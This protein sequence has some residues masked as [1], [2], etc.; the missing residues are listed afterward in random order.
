MIAYYFPPLGGIGSL[1]TAKFASYLPDFGW[2][3]TVVAPRNGSYYRDP[4]LDSGEATVVRTGSLELSRL[5]KRAMGF[6]ARDTQ[7]AAAEGG[8]RFLRD[9]ARRWL[10]FPDAQI[11]WFPFALYAARRALRDATHSVV[12]SSSFPITA[13][14]VARR[15]SCS[16]GLPWVAEF[17]DPWTERLDLPAP[18]RRHALSLELSL[19]R[20]ASVVVAPSE[21]WARLYAD[22]GA[23]RVAVITNGFDSSDHPPLSPPTRFVI[24]HVGSQYP[25]RQDLSAVWPAL[26]RLRR[27]GELPGLAV[28]FV[29]SI[30]PAVLAAVRGAG[31]GNA[32]EVTGFLSHKEALAAMSR[33]TLLLLAGPRQVDPT[34]T[35]CIA[36]KVFEYLATGLPILYVGDPRMEVAR[37]LAGQAGCHVIPAGDVDGVERVLRRAPHQGTVARDLA[38]YGRKALTA[39]LAHIFDEVAP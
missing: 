10:Y 19:I 2:E 5:G 22:K 20:A 17:R 26:A 36:G 35:G 9:L 37:M 32:L 14:L 11:G 24:T 13:H 6:D 21:G 7:P 1:R 27:A 16:L 25:N 3:P 4:S 8:R 30:A 38:A 18:R 31:L 23:R 33:S 29:G 12:F 15:I 39:R 28:R 34:E